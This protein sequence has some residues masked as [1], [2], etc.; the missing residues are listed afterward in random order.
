MCNQTNYGRFLQFHIFIIIFGITIASCSPKEKIVVRYVPEHPMSEAEKK[1]NYADI[2][3]DGDSDF[4]NALNDP[5]LTA[6]T[7]EFGFTVIKN[8]I[9]PF[10]SEIAVADV[11]PWSSWWFPKRDPSFLMIQKR[12]VQTIIIVF[13]S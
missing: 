5:S 1:K 6:V 11:V 4:I 10:R 3:R 12:K 7:N 13:L 9:F 8:K 2:L